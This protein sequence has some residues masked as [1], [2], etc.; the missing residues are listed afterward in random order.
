VA[1]DIKFFRLDSFEGGYEH[2]YTVKL[3]NARISSIAS[4]VSAPL[5]PVAG[6]STKEIVSLSFQSMTLIDEIRG[7]TVVVSGG[8]H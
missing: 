2:F 8:G 1:A 7:N 4:A 6:H 5:E 3:Q